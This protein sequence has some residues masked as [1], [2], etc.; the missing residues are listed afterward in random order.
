MYKNAQGKYSL[1]FNRGDIYEMIR[2]YLTSFDNMNHLIGY[3][4]KIESKCSLIP[5]LRLFAFSI[6]T[7][8][9]IIINLLYES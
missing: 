9:Y 5:V 2:R 6:T 3:N 7:S 8:E 4:F 1:L